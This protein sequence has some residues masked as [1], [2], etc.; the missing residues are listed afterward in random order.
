MRPL[1]VVVGVAVLLV[2]TAAVQGDSAGR[3]DQKLTKDKE[4]IHVLNRL[5]YGPRPGEADDV[6]RVGVEKWI[7]RRS[8][9]IPRST[10]A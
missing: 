3:F 9:R 7:P 8:R 2:T 10:S 1:G 5:T 4:A 6:R